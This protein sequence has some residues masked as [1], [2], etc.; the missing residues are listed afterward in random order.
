MDEERLQRMMSDPN[1]Q[2]SMNEALNNPDFVN[3]LID[4]NPMLRNMPNARQIISSPFMRQMMSD[5]Q[6]MTQAMRMQR[7]MGGGEGFPAPGATDSTAE[8]T[9]TGDNSGTNTNNDTSNQNAFNP[10]MSPFMMPG[11]GAG[12]GAGA[13]Q[14]GGNFMELAMRQLR[15]MGMGNY[16]G[17]STAEQGQTASQPGTT[18]TAS[19]TT[20]SQG[21]ES[22]GTNQSSGTT[23]GQQG[24]SNPPPA[25][26]FAALFGGA[27]GFGRNDAAGSGMNPEMMQS[28]M[29]FM[30]GGGLPGMNAAA[31]A[32]NRPPEE[33]YAEQLRQLND[34]GFYDFDRNV[35]A[36]RRSGGSV[37]GAIEHLL[38]GN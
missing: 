6:M 34:M 36:L 1:V 21:T 38:G 15:D 14:N 16:T 22:Q 27:G 31:P 4:S 3:M 29:E 25:N 24:T 2:Q 13:G 35:A 37:Q 20:P 11:A 32:D 8:G 30:R 17:N 5:P 10:F 18:Q 26:P 33:R 19:G 28:M 9:A 12:A 23:A 7:R